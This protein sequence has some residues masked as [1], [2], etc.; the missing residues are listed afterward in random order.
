[1]FELPHDNQFPS[2]KQIEAKL[3]LFPTSVDFIKMLLAE[4]QQSV[5]NENSGDLNQQKS[6]NNYLNDIIQKMKDKNRKYKVT[7][8]VAYLAEALK[9]APLSSSAHVYII[10]INNNIQMQDPALSQAL[11]TDP[12]E[13]SLG[14]AFAQNKNRR[15]VSKGKSVARN[16]IKDDK[17][18]TG[19]HL[20]SKGTAIT[21][22]RNISTIQPKA[23]SDSE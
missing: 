17:A 8:K 22:G 11:K 3:P 4:P 5:S 12:S 15:N 19:V 18:R 1:M 23:E 2:S 21:K 9:A 13:Q 10:V 20:S 14:E 6:L 7:N 16:E